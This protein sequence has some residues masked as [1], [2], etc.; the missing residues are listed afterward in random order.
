MVRLDQGMTSTNSFFFFVECHERLIHHLGKNDDL[1]CALLLP[2]AGSTTDE[3]TEVENEQLPIDLQYLPS[4]KQREPDRDIQQILL[5]TILLVCSSEIPTIAFTCS[6]F[7]SS[8]VQRNLSAPISVRKTSTSFFESFISSRRSISVA[9]ERANVSF[10][11]WSV[12]KINKWIQIIS[13]NWI[14]PLICERNSMRSIE[15]KPRKRTKRKRKY[16]NKTHQPYFVVTGW[17][18]WKYSFFFTCIVSNHDTSLFDSRWPQH[19]WRSS[20]SGEPIPMVDCV[21]MNRFGSDQKG[22]I[23]NTR[24]WNLPSTRSSGK[25]TPT[26]SD[27]LRKTDQSTIDE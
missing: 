9:V 12:T 23:Q 3:L 17:W 1:I 14:F 16:C 27:F 24:W 6:L 20:F 10:K 25:I 7:S 4:D 19:S 11:S 21:Q 26:G 5:E 22:H 15:K 13:W 18:R 2:L 8:Y